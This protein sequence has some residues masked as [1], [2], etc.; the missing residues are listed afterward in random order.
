MIYSEVAA[1]YSKALFDLSVS[2]GNQDDVFSGLRVVKQLIDGDKS[3]HEFF[4]S[5]VVRASDKESAIAKA[6]KGSGLPKSVEDFL[7]L[8]AKKNRISLF[9]EIVAAYQDKID[10][11]H[12]VTRGEVESATVL[13]P[14]ERKSV[15]DIVSRATGKRVI[16]TYKEDPKLIG[17]LV[18]RVGSYTFDD[19]IISHLRRLKEELKRSA[20]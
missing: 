6:F 17:G 9:S 20:H 18:A 2:E 12:G 10:E 13:T 14:E 5:P 3:L 19:S 1:R 8:L 15:E 4:A 16:L 11:A 7:C